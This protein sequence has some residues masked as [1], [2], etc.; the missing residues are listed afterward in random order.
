MSGT[1][2]YKEPG[3]SLLDFLKGEYPAG[4]AWGNEQVR[5]VHAEP[6]NPRGDASYAVLTVQVTDG[7]TRYRIYTGHA[8]ERQDPSRNLYWSS[9]ESAIHDPHDAAVPAAWLALLPPLP[10]AHPESLARHTELQ[11]C[12][13]DRARDP[14]RARYS[15][16]RRLL[17]QDE[18]TLSLRL[19]TERATAHARKVTA[20]HTPGSVLDFEKALIGGEFHRTLLITD[21]Q[22]G[23]IWVGT[24]EKTRLLLPDEARHWRF[25]VIRLGWPERGQDAAADLARKEAQKRLEQRHLQGVCHFALGYASGRAGLTAGISDTEANSDFSPLFTLAAGWA[26]HCLQ[27][28]DVTPSGQAGNLNLAG[29]RACETL[30]RLLYGPEPFDVNSDN[31]RSL[32]PFGE[33]ALRTVRTALLFGEPRAMIAARQALQHQDVPELEPRRFA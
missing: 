29:V 18:P 13:R 26:L 23:E 22:G 16:L 4:Q 17:D 11:G 21:V 10:E 19:W 27:N 7:Q 1:S 9:P 32:T 24:D 12:A 33:A 3:L 30:D 14:D 28:T 20:L 6:L 25:E 8:G 2:G 15:E 5:E 31:V